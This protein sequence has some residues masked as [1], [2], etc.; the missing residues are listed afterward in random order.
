MNKTDLWNYILGPEVLDLKKGWVTN[1]LVSL[2][3]SISGGLF[4]TDLN[5]YNKFQI[6][7]HLSNKQYIFKLFVKICKIRFTYSNYYC[8]YFILGI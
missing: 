2:S 4:K 3:E 1:C 7:I 5:H 8:E 6:K